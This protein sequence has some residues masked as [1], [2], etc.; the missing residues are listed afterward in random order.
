MKTTAARLQTLLALL[1]LTLPA[2]K[3]S[4]KPALAQSQSAPQA[5]DTVELE[6]HH[7]SSLPGGLSMRDRPDAAAP[8]TAKIAYGAQI[9]QHRPAEASSGEESKPVSIGGM[10]TY[11]VKASAGGKTGYVIEAYLSDY[12]PPPAGTQDLKGWAESM[13]RHYGSAFNSRARIQN[14]QDPGISIHRQLYDNGAVYGEGQ[15]YEYFYVSLQLPNTSI[16]KVLN[17]IK[18]LKEFEAVFKN[19]APL[20]RG[21]YVVPD[22]SLP[23][24]YQWK[25]TYSGDGTSGWLQSLSISWS[26]GGYSTLSIRELETE[27]IVVYSTGV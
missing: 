16:L 7:Y 2:C 20:K 17:C 1:V 11:W 26:D 22:S 18:N 24:G 4:G 9:E 12:A 19:N 21:S 27:V 25:T 14:I 3:E 13:G 15:G 23:E 6:E 5:G 8:V 10:D